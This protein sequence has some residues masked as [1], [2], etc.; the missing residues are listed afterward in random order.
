MTSGA[1]ASALINIARKVQHGQA[2]NE[3][4]ANTRSKKENGEGN[5]RGGAAENKLLADNDLASFGW[6]SRR[7]LF[8]TTVTFL[9]ITPPLWRHLELFIVYRRLLVESMLLLLIYRL[10]LR[11]PL[12]RP[13]PLSPVGLNFHWTILGFFVGGDSYGPHGNHNKNLGKVFGSQ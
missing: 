5:D 4:K 6:R 2:Q 3:Q 10:S 11:P 13:I 12:S 1:A 9:A 7:I 8:V